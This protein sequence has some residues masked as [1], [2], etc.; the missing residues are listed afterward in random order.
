MNT[1]EKSLYR[2]GNAKRSEK[3]KACINKRGAG[4]IFTFASSYIHINVL[5]FAV[6][7]GCRIGEVLGLKWEDCDFERRKITINKTIHYSKASSPVEGSKFST[8]LQ[9]LCLVIEQFR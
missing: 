6:T 7:T 5:K 4:K 3:G 9:K 2:C 8:R 1:S